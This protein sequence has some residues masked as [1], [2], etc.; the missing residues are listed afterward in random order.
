MNINSNYQYKFISILDSQISVLISNCPPPDTI[1]L[2]F[3]NKKDI[4]IEIFGNFRE[5]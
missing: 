2:D 4:F 1:D 5:K 3:Q